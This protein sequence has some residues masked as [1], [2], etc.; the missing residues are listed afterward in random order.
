MTNKNKTP[1]AHISKIKRDE[2]LHQIASYIIEHN[3][4]IDRA[5][6][7]FAIT[8]LN[9]DDFQLWLSGSIYTGF[10]GNSQNF[11]MQ[12]I[13]KV[14]YGSNQNMLIGNLVHLARDVSL[15]YKFIHGKLPNLMIPIRSIKKQ[16]HKEF[17]FLRPEELEKTSKINIFKL[18]TK[19]FKVYF[20]EV[21]VFDTS[22]ESEVDMKVDLPLEMFKNINNASKFKLSGIADSVYVKNEKFGIADLKTSKSKISGFA[23]MDQKLSKLYEE[24][25]RIHTSIEECDKKLKKLS[26]ANKNLVVAKKALVDVEVK[27]DEAKANKKATLGLEKRVVSWTAKVQ[28]AIFTVEELE[29]SS[30]VRLDLYREL[31]EINELI[32]PLKQRLDNEKQEADLAACIKAHGSQLTHYA[33]TY[34]IATG[35]PVKYLRIENIVKA[36]KPY[37]QIFEWELSDKALEDIEEKIQSI[38]SLVE[39]SLDGIDPLILFRANPTGFIGRETELFKDEIKAII[40]AIENQ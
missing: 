33:L 32:K 2:L 29:E 9:R 34:M 17:Q 16:L 11:M 30:E 18:A 35:K 38:I 6:A 19:L 21:L 13:V 37:A 10:F 24:K 27:L 14:D 20:K 26:S 15:K 28:E 4:T 22:I 1:P 40:K 25:K 39:L 31:S 7:D 3:C 12:K 8:S 5:L 23:E 36:E